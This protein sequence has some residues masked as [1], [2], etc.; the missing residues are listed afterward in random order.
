MNTQKQSASGSRMATFSLEPDYQALMR[1][2]A[3]KRRMNMSA[4]LRH[5]LDHDAA[6]LGVQPLTPVVSAP[7]FLHRNASEVEG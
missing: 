2:L 4:Y 7:T 5:L 3:R 1:K 6:L